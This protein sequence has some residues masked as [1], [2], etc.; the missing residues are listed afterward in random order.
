MRR[1]FFTYFGFF[2]LAGLFLLLILNY[3]YPYVNPVV[4][5]WSV[6]YSFTDE[7]LKKPNIDRENIITYPEVDSFLK[8]SGHYIADPFFIEDKDTFYLFVELKGENDADIALF[9]SAEGENYKYKG[10]VL[11]EDFHLSFPQVF[12]HNN[13]YYMLPETSQTG[14]VI[15]YKSA[16]FPY[17]WQKTDTLI[18]N[19]KLKDPA[20]LLSK[21]LNLIVAVDDH[22]QQYMFT[23]DS[24]TGLWKEAENYTV[25]LGNETRPGG[26]FFEFNDNH[27]LPI[28]DRRYGYGSAISIFRLSNIDNHLELVREQKE[29][30]G[31]QENIKWFNRGMHQLD[32]Q[33]VGAEYYMVYDGD[34]NIDGEGYFQFKRSLKFVYSDF[35]NLF[36]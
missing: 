3:F 16:D 34:Y 13:E 21:D 8:K 24:L 7:V 36:Q 31:P 28:Q 6:G 33:K 30:L 11:D 19:R 9:T 15:L 2:L 20:I 10:V 14:N 29:Y 27:Y 23:A 18:K 12:K 25:R 17:N 5:K 32:I 1:R 35:Y 22:M 4:G 26:R